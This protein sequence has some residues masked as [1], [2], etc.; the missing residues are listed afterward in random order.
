MRAPEVWAGYG[1]RHVSDVYSVG[2]TI[3]SWLQPGILGSHDVKPPIF[4]DAWC[5]A[6]MVKLVE[7]EDERTLDPP[8]GVANTVKSM[9]ELGRVLLTQPEDDD[10]GSMHV[11][12]RPLR[13]VLRK[14]NSTPEV[15]S[16]L[17]LLLAP[18]FQR[19]LSA[20]QVLKSKAYEALQYAAVSKLDISKIEQ[21][22]SAG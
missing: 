8:A 13:D 19:R 17:R 21:K 2:S 10:S 12:A 3:I 9:Y 4:I 11:P 18:N 6:K 20:V 5:I 1:C 22:V 14:M 7:T 16:L 15:K